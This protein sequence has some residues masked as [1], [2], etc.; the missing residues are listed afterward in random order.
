MATQLHAVRNAGAT[1]ARSVRENRFSSMKEKDPKA[2][3][4]VEVT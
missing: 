3:R 1:P 2:E 4:M